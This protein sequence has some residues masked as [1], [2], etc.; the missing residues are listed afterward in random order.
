MQVPVGLSRAYAQRAGDRVRLVELPGVEHFALIDPLSAAWP[1][2]VD[3]LDTLGA[4][5]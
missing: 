4:R 2:V 3:A 1:T 5:P